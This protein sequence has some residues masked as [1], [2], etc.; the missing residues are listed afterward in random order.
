MPEF[1]SS[2]SASERRASEAGA[3]G[4]L[5][6]RQRSGSAGRT[7]GLAFTLGHNRKAKHGTVAEVDEFL[8]AVGANVVDIDRSLARTAAQLRARH[9][10]LRLPDAVAPATA[11][12]R[13]AQLLT[14][15][16]DLQQIA[17]DAQ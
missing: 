1:R 3:S 2:A 12:Q 13:N 15:D 8:A 11:L 17:A 6:K 10:R 5:R 9:R 16:R 14:L 7:H 4:S